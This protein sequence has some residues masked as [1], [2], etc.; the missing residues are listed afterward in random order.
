[1]YKLLASVVLHTRYIGSW[2]PGAVASDDVNNHSLSG[3]Q[4]WESEIA[5]ESYWED[6]LEGKMYV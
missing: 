6:G 4:R 1:M 5:G 3:K 2:T